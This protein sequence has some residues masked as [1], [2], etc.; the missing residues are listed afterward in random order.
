MCSIVAGLTALAGGMQ[1]KAQQDAAS[2][3]AAMYRQRAATAEQN[4]KIENRRQEE[5]ADQYADSQRRLRAQQRLA[6]GAQRA[7][8]GSAGLDFT[9]SMSDLLSS[10]NE[11]AMNDQITLLTNQ[12]NDNYNSRLTQ[13][14]WLNQ[15]SAART[16]ASNVTA[17]ARSQGLATILGTAASVYGALQ[18][19]K[20]AGGAA[21]AGRAT[22]SSAVFSNWSQANKLGYGVT[23]RQYGFNSFAPRATGINTKIIF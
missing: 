8:A 10:A 16:A 19:W 7:A 22:N 2:A 6:E 4:A 12:R 15:A 3:Q 21:K 9:G 17:N 20:A 14:N 18:P 5:I 13:S 11:Q 1:Y 23:P